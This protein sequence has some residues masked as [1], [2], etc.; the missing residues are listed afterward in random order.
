L[1]V[2]KGVIPLGAL[3]EKLEVFVRGRK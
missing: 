2:Y 3:E 1:L